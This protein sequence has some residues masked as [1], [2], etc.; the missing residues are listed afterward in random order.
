[1]P[2]RRPRCVILRSDLSSL[3]SL[4]CSATAISATSVGVP[5]ITFAG[6]V[7]TVAGATKKAPAGKNAM[8]TGTGQ[9]AAVGVTR[10]V[11][12]DSLARL[13]IAVARQGHAMSW[14]L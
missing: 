7:L 10:L 8:G 1:M 4:S 5:A 6:D 9:I 12:I 2:A 3:C 11:A 14:N 13:T